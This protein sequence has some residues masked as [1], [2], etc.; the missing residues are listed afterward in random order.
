VTWPAKGRSRSNE[1]RRKLLAKHPK[2]RQACKA[3]LKS[4]EAT[5]EEKHDAMLEL[6]RLPRDSSP[7]R[8]RNRCA[9]TGADRMSRG[10]HYIRSHV[11][12]ARVHE[13]EGSGNAGP[14][15]DPQPLADVLRDVFDPNGKPS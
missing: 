8:L 6:Q 10:I 12:D 3:V 4:R 14:M 1:K 13:L 5:M 11:P 2:R 15:L 9:M 7:T